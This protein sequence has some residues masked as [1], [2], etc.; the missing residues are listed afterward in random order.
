MTRLAYPQEPERAQQ[1]A[2]GTRV[3]LEA[4]CELYP[5]RTVEHVGG[6][7][8]WVLLVTSKRKRPLREMAKVLK[9]CGFVRVTNHR[10]VY[11]LEIPSH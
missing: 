7:L 5:H 1:A 6:K 11:V 2:L 10:W 3:A 9:A 4:K 8:V